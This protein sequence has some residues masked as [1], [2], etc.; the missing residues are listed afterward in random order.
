MIQVAL[1]CGKCQLCI[2]LGPVGNSD[3]LPLASIQDVRFSEKEEVMKNGI[4]GDFE[5]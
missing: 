4:G 2:K 1:L 3:P 5:G